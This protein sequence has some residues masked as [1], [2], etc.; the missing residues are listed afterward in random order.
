MHTCVYFCTLHASPYYSVG[1]GAFTKDALP[2]LGEAPHASAQLDARSGT[3]T[4]P[5]DLLI[6]PEFVAFCGCGHLDGEHEVLNSTHLPWFIPKKG[7][8]TDQKA[9]QHTIPISLEGLMLRSENH[10]T[11][12]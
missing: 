5:E 1:S 11:V 8:P 4:Y 2:L 12:N 7:K 6:G 10:Q 9:M 3:G